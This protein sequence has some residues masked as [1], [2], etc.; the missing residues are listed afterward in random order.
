MNVMQCAIK[1]ALYELEWAISQTRDNNGQ[2]ESQT[3]Y[4]KFATTFSRSPFLM[5]QMSEQES[6][7]AMLLDPESIA[8]AKELYEIAINLQ[9]RVNAEFKNGWA[10]LAGLVIESVE[11]L[12]S[13][14]LI[15]ID[16]AKRMDAAELGESVFL[17][18]VIMYY[19]VRDYNLIQTGVFSH[20]TITKRPD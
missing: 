10:D 3:V 11:A 13:S 5:A 19:A 9:T 4:R 17:T 6:V 12:T 8:D 16:A 1:W 18:M 14:D 2:E 7:R 20:E 15:A